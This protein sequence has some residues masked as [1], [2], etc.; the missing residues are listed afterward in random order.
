MDYAKLGTSVKRLENARD[1]AA[2]RGIMTERW[3]AI[4][5]SCL[6]EPQEITD[7]QLG[8]IRELVD[9]AYRTVPLY[10]EKY[11]REGFE[12]GDLRGWKDFEALP[13]LGKEELIAAFPDRSVSSGHT[14]EFTTRSTG[15]SGQFVTLVVSPNAVYEDT[16][17]GVRQFHFQS[18]RDYHPEDLLLH[19]YTCPWWVSSV[20]GDYRTEFLPTTTLPAAAAK[21]IVRMRPKILSL[22]PTYLKSLASA[23]A[24]L[25]GSGVSLIVVHSEQTSRSERAELEKTFGIPVRDEFSSEELTRIALECPAGRYHLEEDAC[26][27]EILDE[28]KRVSDGDL[29]LVVGTNLLNEATPV[30]RY[31]QGDLA[32]LTGR[33]GCGCGSNFRELSAPAG[34]KMDNITTPSGVQIPAG[35]FMDLAYNWYLDSGIPVHA[36]KYRIVQEET[37]DVRVHIVPGEHDFTPEMGAV[38]KE[39]MYSLLPRTMNV[40]VLVGESLPEISGIK[41]RPIVSKYRRE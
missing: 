22:Y 26:Y 23:E 10:R 15:S 8:R 39:S 34:R 28:G 4:R 33:T 2:L 38:V 19:I 6:R 24:D 20:D 5:D 3:P 41:Q 40:D 21:E 13:L 12:P 1:H 17:Q 37:G 7:W 27:I 14:M 30:I 18:G 31:S 25:K 9:H 29:G 36:L 11:L 35:A 32:A 16:I